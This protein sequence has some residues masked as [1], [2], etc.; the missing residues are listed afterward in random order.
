ASFCTTTP[1]FH[2]GCSS[3]HGSPSGPSGQYV[4]VPLSPRYHQV[5]T[6][7]IFTRCSVNN[8]DLP[9][10]FCNHTGEFS[11]RT[12]RNV[13]AS[14][15]VLNPLWCGPHKLNNINVGFAYCA[16]Q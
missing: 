15:C 5:L 14:R 3:L 9:I 16:P 6:F 13:T 12:P 11:I 8:P 4:N 1:L 10:T 7:A 2:S